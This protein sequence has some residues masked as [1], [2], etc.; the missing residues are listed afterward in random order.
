MIPAIGTEPIRVEPPP[1]DFVMVE[2]E[3][4]LRGPDGE[5][6]RKALVDRF[7]ALDAMIAAEISLGLSPSA[8]ERVNILREALAS[9]RKIVL[10]FR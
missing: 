5:Q 9:A 4:S 1:T 8:F 7:D 2:F 6:T 10:K 3:R